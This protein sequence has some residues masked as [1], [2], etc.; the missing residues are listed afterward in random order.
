MRDAIDPQAFCLALVDDRCEVPFASPILDLLRPLDEELRDY[1]IASVYALLIGHDRRKRLSAYFTPPSLVAAA[2][3][4][5]DPFLRHRNPY[6]LDP[7]CGGGSFL[8]PVALRLIRAKR[9][10]GLPPSQAV[11]ETLQRLKGIELDPG[12]AN[13]S[14]ALLARAVRSR[15]GSGVNGTIVQ[16]EN[17]LQVNPEPIYDLVVGN[18]PYGRIAGR[19]DDE[20][21]SRAGRANMGGHTNLYALFLLQALAWLKPGGG[22]VFVLPTSFVAG[23]YFDGLRHEV[24]QKAKVLRIDAHEQRDD[25]FVDA[26]QDVCVLTLQR[27][28]GA[29]QP[30]A[31]D[32]PYE[33]GLVNAQGERL[34]LGHSIA[35]REGEPWMLPHGPAPFAASLPGGDGVKKRGC[36]LSDYGYRVRVGKVV[37]TR[38][39]E[40]LRTKPG[41]DTLPLLWASSVRPDGTFQFAN[42]AN[43]KLASWYTPPLGAKLTYATTD[44][45]VIVQRTSNREQKR[46]LNAA[47]VSTEFYSKQARNGFVAENHVIVLE[48][49]TS[50]PAVAPAIVAALLNA[51]RTNERFSTVSGS[52][53]VSAKLLCRLILPPPDC[54]PHA[55]GPDF[56]RAVAD[57]FDGLSDL[58]APLVRTG[59]LE[60]GVDQ[61]RRLDRTAT[62]DENPSFKRRAIA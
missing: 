48:T 18:P 39:R 58:L 15:Y 6:V 53:S 3:Q 17:A 47:P 43:E 14:M 2:M 57:A 31:E 16:T 4:A 44:R 56:D 12:L 59:D 20:T 55:V 51:A 8:A 35:R 22:L 24:L 25:L 33:M 40:Q 9:A 38:E 5:A 32:P 23:P 26:I 21:L 42:G 1:A 36:T 10:A 52:F 49:A 34:L 11:A 46:R 27:R 60:D 50:S 37:P 13:L 30:M 61:P 54:L 41:K 29:E 19:V 7:A 28:T 45:A 62:V